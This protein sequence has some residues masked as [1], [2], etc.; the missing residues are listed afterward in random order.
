MVSVR[1]FTADDLLRLPDDGWRY[2][3]VR[4]GLRKMAPAGKHHGVLAVRVTWRLAQYVEAH[5]LGDVCAA[6]TGFRLSS[7]PD[8]VLAPDVAFISRQRLSEV[9]R[10]VEGYW[11][12]APDLV[13]EVISP[14]DTY[15]EVDTKVLKWLAG[16]ARMVVVINPRTKRVAVYRSPTDV[17]IL[18]DRDVLDGQ[19][20]VPGWTMA[21]AD[22][23]AGPASESAES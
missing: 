22:L 8:T 18:G 23:F 17:T 7:A 15:T 21:L 11:P 5:S 20:V 1:V 12:G 9:G 3:L 13:V 10:E 2:E 4:G 19:D 14:S 6:E 16:G